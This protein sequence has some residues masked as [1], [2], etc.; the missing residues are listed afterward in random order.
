[1]DKLRTNAKN[2]GPVEPLNDRQISVSVLISHLC[3]SQ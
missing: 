3:V 2:V 1:V